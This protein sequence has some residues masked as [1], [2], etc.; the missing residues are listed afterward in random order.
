M[1]T[2]NLYFAARADGT[3]PIKIGRTG[4]LNFRRQALT[5]DA[6][7]KVEMLVALPGLAHLERHFHTLFVADHVGHEWFDRSAALLDTIDQLQAGV[8]DMGT[9]PEP[10]PLPTERG[11]APR[12]PLSRVRYMV[13]GPALVTRK[14]GSVTI[15]PL[16]FLTLAQARAEARRPDTAAA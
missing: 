12:N 3:G 6:G 2:D 10:K 15:T 8:F 16:R 5:L 11:K 7:A 9:L 4:N 14:D 13:K 1:R